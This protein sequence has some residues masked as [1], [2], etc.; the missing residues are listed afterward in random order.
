MHIPVCAWKSED[1][2]QSSIKTGLWHADIGDCQAR[3]PTNLLEFTCLLSSLNRSTRTIDTC[4]QVWHYK[5]SE[6]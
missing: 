2:S 6:S 1:I 4:Y 5:V 3:W